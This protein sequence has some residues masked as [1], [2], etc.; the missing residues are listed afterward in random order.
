MATPQM[1]T[2]SEMAPHSFSMGSLSATLAASLLAI[3]SANLL[4]GPPT[5]VFH[6][7]LE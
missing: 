4:C 3:Q 5:Q 6:A 7:I 1:V 2:A